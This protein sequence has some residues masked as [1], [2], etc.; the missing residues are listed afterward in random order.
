[1]AYT[2]S[3]SEDDHVEEAASSVIEVELSPHLAAAGLVRLADIWN[4]TM[5]EIAYTE[6]WNGPSIYYVL[7][8][9]KDNEAICILLSF[10]D[11]RLEVLDF[12]STMILF[13]ADNGGNLKD[14]SKVCIPP[15]STSSQQGYLHTQQ[16]ETFIGYVDK[17]RGICDHKET[18]YMRIVLSK[19]FGEQPAY[20]IYKYSSEKSLAARISGI[21]SQ[22][23]VLIQIVGNVD[24]ASKALLICLAKKVYRVFLKETFKSLVQCTGTPLSIRRI[25]EQIGGGPVI[26]LPEINTSHILSASST[27]G[28]DLSCM[29][30]LKDVY[31]TKLAN[32]GVNQRHVFTINT[33]KNE[34]ALLVDC[35]LAPK[36]MAYV[37]QLDPLQTL[38]Y[39]EPIIGY[40]KT[41]RIHVDGLKIGSIENGHDLVDKERNK[42]MF[43]VSSRGSN[44]TLNSSKFKILRFGQRDRPALARIS[45]DSSKR[46]VLVRF[47]PDCTSVHWRVMILSLAVRHIY[48]VYS[49]SSHNAPTVEGFDEVMKMLKV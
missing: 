30:A 34:V 41:S 16:C 1:M 11:G 38:F 37:Q 35:K 7:R 13:Q 47:A 10:A 12:H 29:S 27:G 42:V 32:I 9:A 33:S 26:Q 17:D 43:A 44:E 20:D 23:C 14:M 25:A 15:K 28:T 39:L 18:P 4:L 46:K 8:N 5:K 49:C 2:Y 22:R 36:E 6:A 3:E 21:A 40:S 19:Q 24:V 45:I 48:N 31:I